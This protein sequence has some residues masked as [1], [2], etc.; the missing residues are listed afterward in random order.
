MSPTATI[1]VTRRVLQQLRRDHRTAAMLIVVPV[2]LI[3]LLRYMFDGQP[4]VFDRVGGTMIG[5]F[6]LIV[7]FLVTS[8]S[9]LRERTSGTLERLMTLPMGKADLLLGY[10]L[11]FALVAALQALVVTAIGVGVLGIDV[12]GPIWL[13]VAFSIGNGLLG[14]ALGLLLSAFA[15]S[16]FQAVQFMPAVIMPQLLLCGLIVPRESMARA[17]DIA[18][19]AL[20]MTYAYDGLNRVATHGQSLSTNQVAI[21]LAVVYGVV[22]AAILLG[23]LTLRRRTP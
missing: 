14:M 15:T 9:M 3:T 23:G 17:L 12:Q 8:V 5:I 1:A 21:D 6:P 7:M 18:A 2:L 11:A 4:L 10:G 13:V 16:E 19:G 22:V 20:P